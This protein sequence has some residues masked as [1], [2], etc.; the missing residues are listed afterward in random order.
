MIL[1]LDVD[2]KK[3]VHIVPDDAYLLVLGF[4][5]RRKIKHKVEITKTKVIKQ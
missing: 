3:H 1:N 5:R 4:L 2:G